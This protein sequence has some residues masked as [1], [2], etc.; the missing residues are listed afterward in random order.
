MSKKINQLGQTPPWF[1]NSFKEQI[2]FIKDPS[3]LKAA[4]CTRRAGKSFGMGL[5]LCKTAYENPG[6]SVLY[7]ALTRDSAER[8]MWK[9]VLKV[10]NRD[11][12]LSIKFNDYKLTATFPNGS[13]LYLM[14]AD[15]REEE[16]NKMLGQ[17][18]KLVVIDEASKYRIDV[19]KMIFDVLKPAVSDYNG[20]IA[21]IGTPDNFVNSYFAR[22]AMGYDKNWSLHKWSAIN[23]PHMTLQFH[24]EIEDLKAKTPNIEEEAWFR[25]NYIG[26]WVVDT[27]A[28]V[29]QYT[30]DN[31][32]KT[33][34]D[35]KKDWTYVLGAV[36]N[37]NG[38]SALSIVAYSPE[39]PDAYIIEAIKWKAVDL[40]EVIDKIISFAGI[41]DFSQVN[42]IDASDKMVEEIQ[43]RFPISVKKVQEKEKPGL[44]QLFTSDLNSGKIKVLLQNS[45]IIREWESV[46][47]DKSQASSRK[48]GIH[49]HPF[50]D[51]Q[52]STAALFAW[53]ESYHYG[54]SPE[55]KSDDPNDDFWE[56]QAE[57]LESERYRELDEFNGL[58]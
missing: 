18:Y 33:M 27:K 45:D 49:I 2:D 24:K 28:L 41:Y 55:R 36:L 58:A 23:N 1:K 52:A 9:D 10:I 44:I 13:V 48:H 57:D 20:Q 19:H 39:V 3:P 25:Q 15:S 17:K 6:V 40:H 31:I 35:I 51:D 37:S 14:G 54:Y 7:V 5:Y 12:N 21:L 30:S 29:Y 34:P 16:M 53:V 47:K 4:Q 56:R 38:Y 26:E 43:K 32:V 46:L 42:C 8:I 11:F 22:I 50:S